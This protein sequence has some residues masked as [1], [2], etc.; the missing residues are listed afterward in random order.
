MSITGIITALAAAEVRFVV[1]GGVAAGIHGSTHTTIDVDLCYDP[2]SGNVV[3]LARLLGDWHPYP[4]G[5]EAGLPFI[6]DARTLQ[7]TPVLTL[8]T[9]HG[10][11]DLLDRV[12]G[13]GPYDKVLAGSETAEIGGVRFQVLGLPALLASKRATR[14]PK[15]RAQ[16]PELEALLELTRR[17]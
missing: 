11:L 4:R 12:E 16:I 2:E 15:D 3:R 7:I 10:P 14:R 17:G 5:I 6:M 13:V 1:I 8:M 9:D